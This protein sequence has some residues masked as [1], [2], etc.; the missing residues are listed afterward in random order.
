MRLKGMGWAVAALV[1]LPADSDAAGWGRRGHGVLTYDAATERVGVNRDIARLM[2]LGAIAPDYFEFDNPAAHSQTRDP[3]IDAA[4]KPDLDPQR[5][6]A[7]QSESFRS[8]QTWRQHYF[9][10][11]VAAA[12]DGQRE[13]A[14][15]MLGYTL[16]NV[17]DYGTHRGIPNAL[18][19]GLDAAGHS[20]DRDETRL[21][22]AKVL[23]SIY[24]ERFR[25][26]IGSDNWKL[27]NGEA[28]R[29]PGQTYA[30]VPAP[31]TVVSGLADW[32]P[33]SG[34]IPPAPGYLRKDVVKSVV[35]DGLALLAHPFCAPNCQ[36][37]AEN[38]TEKGA[39]FIDG[40]LSRQEELAGLLDTRAL[41][42]Q[43]PAGMTAPQTKSDDDLRQFVADG[44]LFAVDTRRFETG[45]ALYREA[46]RRLL[47]EAW[48]RIN[49]DPAYWAKRGFIAQYALLSDRERLFLRQTSFETLMRQEI[50]R[51][52]GER[53]AKRERLQESLSLTL[54][55]LKSLRDEYEAAQRTL[56]E[57]QAREARE[58]QEW[59]GRQRA[60][61]E[62]GR[63]V[64]DGRPPPPEIRPSGGG[65]GGGSR[66]PSEWREPRE[67]REPRTRT[68]MDE[69]RRRICGKFGIGC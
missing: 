53:D 49:P 26:E 9:E 48:K 64:I 60:L 65:G 33:R 29:R 28:V 46:W 17:E 7:S 4:G 40:F 32:D 31:L 69:P 62:Q 52:T 37:A 51:L 42:L 5:Y 43:L 41:G 3:E 38:L 35:G 30:T 23:A 8:A 1:L 56:S 15:L 27:F 68:D 13:R 10:A 54:S 2:A 47:P 63:P 39:N 19:A 57:R 14:A 21:A 20:P 55:D 18:H 36:L 6:A 66:E 24:I 16:H 45:N 25:E 67:P 34:F 58:R 44:I 59:Q 11:A 50:E 61:L 12:K 22:S